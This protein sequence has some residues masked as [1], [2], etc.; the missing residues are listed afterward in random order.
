MATGATTVAAHTSTNSQLTITFLN[1][2]PAT[3]P[4]Q[5]E[6]ILIQTPDGKTA[7]IDGGLDAASLGSE[8]DSRLPF[9]QHTLDMVLLTSPRQ[10][11]LTGL[12]DIVS[13]YQVGEAVDAGMLHPTT[14]YA[15]YRRT[16][17]ER[18]IP[19]IQVRQGATIT[20]GTQ[21]AIQVFWPQSPLHKGSAENED[22]GLIVRLLAPGLRML[23][24]DS[25]ALSKYALAGLLATIGPGYLAADVVQITGDAGKSFPTALPAVLQAIHPSLL[26]ISPAALSPKLRKAGASSV[27]TS[28]Q[29]ISGSWQ[30]AQTAQ[31]GT[32]QITSNGRSWTVQSDA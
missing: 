2:G 26:I 7:L 27:L 15:L 11:D 19:Y 30:I 31:T 25:A 18:N 6:A 20:L 16:I 23:L 24:L 13:R 3:Q 32:M 4:V 1:V 17:S 5:G 12:I 28:L 22:N 10:D 21:L 9:W 8:L 14:N 29:S